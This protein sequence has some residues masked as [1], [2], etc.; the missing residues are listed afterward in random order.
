MLGS[1]RGRRTE[2]CDEAVP[3]IFGAHRTL[4]YIEGDASM[5]KYESKEGKVESALSIV[6]RE[7]S[8]YHLY[9][10]AAKIR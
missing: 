3:L 1:E 7:S 4:V 6:Q 9:V 10:F 8:R 2:K 5:R